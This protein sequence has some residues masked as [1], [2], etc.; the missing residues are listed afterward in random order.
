[1]GSSPRWDIFCNVVDHFGDIA[2]SWRLARQLQAE[3]GMAVRLFVD[4][5][6]TFHALRDAVDPAADTQR[7]D[8][9]DIVHWTDTLQ[10]DEVGDVVIDAFGSRAPDHVL[11]V[12]AK[13][14]QAPVWINLEYLSSE[15]WVEDCHRLASPHPRL[16]LVRYFFFPGFTAATGG[17][18]EERRL[19][20]ER[21]AFLGNA[22]ARQASLQSW[23]VQ[24]SAREGARLVTLFGYGGPSVASLLRAWADNDE[25]VC[26]L[27][28]QGRMVPDIARF[29]RRTTMNP[30]DIALVGALEVQVLPFG[31]QPDYDRL[32]WLADVNF[33]RGEDSFVRAQ[34]A[35]SP[36]VWNIYPQEG[37][38]HWA[39]LHAFIDRYGA[40]L[41][42]E[43]VV[44]LREFWRLWN[45]GEI[46]SATL[47][48]AWRRFRSY[49]EEL[50]VH[51]AAW[52]AHLRSHHDL[53]TNLVRFAVEKL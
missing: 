17:V 6:T 16:P 18:L 41:E 21:A 22:A 23:G 52:A 12:M 47:G 15:S 5:L 19:A 42:P 34:W 35:E 7:V 9:I 43:V 24:P 49:A 53:A 27:V 29:L 45:R 31:T 40:G 48:A 2:V 20:A 14:R 38:A 26:A 4:D 39:K 1:M 46:S 51:N 33:V 50:R 32:L 28:P 8:N 11:E 13:R 25:P 3:H 36:F 10:V 30:G 37:G 44:A